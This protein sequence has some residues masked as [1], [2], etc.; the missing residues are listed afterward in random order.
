M[1]RRLPRFIRFLTTTPS[2]SS[3]PSSSYIYLDSVTP[4]PIARFDPRS[5]LA[6][7]QFPTQLISIQSLVEDTLSRT[8]IPLTLDNIIPR[9][10]D[11][12][13]LIK[14]SGLAQESE[15]RSLEESLRE[16]VSTSSLKSYLIPSFPSLF[17]PPRPTV[18]LVV[19][20][21][22][23]E[24]MHR[25]P[26]RILRVEFEGP[27]PTLEDLYTAFRPVRILVTST[28][29][30]RRHSTEKDRTVW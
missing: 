28:Y 29:D 2:I 5:L 6:K 24:D 10:K 22:F 9:E 21:P 19:G 20:S 15:Q 26:N 11:G 13:V 27:D 18:H 14:F 8:G 25:Y 12:G 23:L 1:I 30:F 7:L 4:I 16:S 17:S 3:I